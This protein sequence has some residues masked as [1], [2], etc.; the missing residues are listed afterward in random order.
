MTL[1]TQVAGTTRSLKLVWPV[2]P[3][4]AW[5]IEPVVGH[6][7]DV[8]NPGRKAAFGRVFRLLPPG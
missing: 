8:E 5:S 2:R 4:Q 6:G 7:P 3:L 1:E